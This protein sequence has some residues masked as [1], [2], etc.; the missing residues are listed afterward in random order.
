[1]PEIQVSRSLHSS[2]VGFMT[3]RGWNWEHFSEGINVSCGEK[4][5]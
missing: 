4:R 3:F 1:M 5:I 2:V